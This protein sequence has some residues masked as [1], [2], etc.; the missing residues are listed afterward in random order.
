MRYLV[1]LL[2]VFSKVAVSGAV[3]SITETVGSTAS[4]E[5][6]LNN[7]SGTKGTAVEK[8]DAVQTGKGKVGITFSDDTRVQV[9]ENSKLIVKEFS[10][11]PKNQK[12]KLG[13]KVALGTVRYASGQ[14]AKNNPA[15]V[16]VT[17]PSATI[18]V[19]GT[20]F[21]ATVDEI[22][23]ST[24]ILLPSC[25]QEKVG[26]PGFDINRDCTTGKIWVET[27]D[28]RVVLDRPFQ[29]TKVEQPGIKP[30][31]P[32]V[33]NLTED[34][35][36]NLLIV[37]PPPELQK[38]KEVSSDGINYAAML[39]GS[40]YDYIDKETLFDFLFANN[41]FNAPTESAPE[42]NE[43]IFIPSNTTTNSNVVFLNKEFLM[44]LST[45]VDVQLN[46][47]AQRNASTGSSSDPD[48]NILP[49]WK[50]QNGST[51]TVDKMSVTLCRN[52][53]T[54]NDNQC[55]TVPSNQNTSITTTVDNIE[56]VNR[57]NQGNGSTITL[58]Q[59]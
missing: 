14:I 2:L 40:D 52:S 38:K 29:A 51:A 39:N 6:D 43:T 22:G 17:T 9:N 42:T 11:D 10:Y 19:R 16:A 13:I 58:I 47:A 27:S 53:S 34:T 28:G 31:Y 59:R 35:I 41:A 26:K 32:V 7:I 21:T 12:G 45:I 33:L 24:I 20:D 23:G 50:N 46:A 36:N 37:S 15:N 30:V 3:G 56:V 1:L 25:P 44:G 49:D 57:I 48:K 5:R 55:V 54:N 18:S 8:N 4:I